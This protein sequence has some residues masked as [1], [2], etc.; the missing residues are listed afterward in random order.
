MNAYRIKNW[1]QHFEIAQS[2]RAATMKMSWVAIPNKHDGKSYRRLTRNPHFAEIFAAWCLIIQVASKQ[3]ERGLL[4]DADG[5][6]TAEDLSDSTGLSEDAF[7]KAF[8]ALSDV[9]IGW[10]ERV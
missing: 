9:K 10:L 6:L 7:T 8:E 5:P 4:A 2:R 3:P 1:D